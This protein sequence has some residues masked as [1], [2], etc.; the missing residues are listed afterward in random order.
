[1]VRLAWGLVL[2][3]PAIGLAGWGRAVGPPGLT[4]HGPRLSNGLTR[5]SAPGRGLSLMA[6]RDTPLEDG[7]P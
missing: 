4:S 5:T 7:K 3:L 1:M 6:Q 2:L